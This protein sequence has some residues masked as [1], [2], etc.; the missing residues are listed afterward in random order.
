MNKL[1]YKVEAKMRS[2]SGRENTYFGSEDKK[3][4]LKKFGKRKV[5]ITQII[6]CLLLLASVM[7]FKNNDSAFSKT[8]SE[9]VD[10]VLTQ[11]T[12]FNELSK[13]NMI[14]TI[15]Q[16]FKNGY[17]YAT[18]NVFSVKSDDFVPPVSG[19]VTSKFENRTHPVFNTTIEARGI[20]I[21]TKNGNDVVSIADGVVKI[22]ATSTIQKQRVV[23]EYNDGILGVYDG[24]V[25]SVKAGDTVKK[26]Q[27]IGTAYSASDN[28][29]VT[30]ELWKDTKA[31]NPEDYIKFNEK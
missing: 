5:L 21:T 8:F 14:N 25:S 26:S 3:S 13:N 1:R 24:I 20:E 2:S 19:T 28:A 7:V 10:K 27:K 30:F 6:V 15:S 16:A 29:V 31:L 17:E 12:D 18:K 22:V 11:Q 9:T 4:K 23:I